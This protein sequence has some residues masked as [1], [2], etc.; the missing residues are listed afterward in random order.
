MELNTAR[1]LESA[2]E[3][4]DTDSELSASAALA[5][6]EGSEIAAD[7]AAAEDTES[8][9]QDSAAAESSAAEAAE[10]ADTAEALP[11]ESGDNAA[12]AEEAAEPGAD[13]A[14]DAADAAGASDGSDIDR[15]VPDNDVPPPAVQEEEPVIEVQITDFP[16]EKFA[17]LSG[18]AAFREARKLL[19]AVLADVRNH[20]FVYTLAVLVCALSVCKVLQVQETRAVTAQLNEVKQSNEDL[21]RV[22]LSLMSERQALSEH[23]RIRSIAV[24][25]LQMQAPATEAEKI[26]T[27]N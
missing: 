25:N 16:A 7:L 20:F 12:A 14:G 18:R 5:Q 6:T 3:L 15:S 2:S 17:F 27:V 26:I 22:W 21:Q 9:L 13:D 19:P 11:A 8:A 10:T 24:D 23:N 1:S 4:T